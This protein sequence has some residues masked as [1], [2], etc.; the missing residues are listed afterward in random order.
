MDKLK[1]IDREFSLTDSTVNVYG[2]RLLTKG[3]LMDEYKKNPIGYLMHKREDGVLVKWEDL[4]VEGD[5]VKGKPVINMSHSRAAQTVDEIENGF[6]NAASVGHIVVLEMSDDPS[7]K[8]SGQTGPTVTKWFNRECSL[9]DVPGNI[10]ALA[11][12]Y[13]ENDNE[14]NLADY[15]TKLKTEM[16]QIQFTAANLAALN[17]TAEAE[18]SAVQTAFQELVSKAAKVPG[19]ETQLN[20]LRAQVCKDKVEGILKTALDANKITKELSDRL[21]KDYATNPEGLKSV[22][23]GLPVY[24]SVTDR[25]D[26]ETPDKKFAPL[27]AKSFNDLM[28]SGEAEILKKQA[29]ELYKQKFKEEFGHEPK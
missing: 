10:N 19:L 27:M 21:A 13:D 28:E 2:F 16:K 26:E 25:L 12:L 15:Q 20:D 29:P 18:E 6:L 4:R 7:L 24:K 3:Y 22:V 23:D 14:I 9:V 8:L 1:K 11:K 17:L 5:T